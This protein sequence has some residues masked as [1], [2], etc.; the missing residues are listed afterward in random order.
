MKKLLMLTAAVLALQA[1]PA[2]AQDGGPDGG[3]KHH[4]GEKFFEMQDTNKDGVISEDEALANAKKRFG[5][6]DG[7]KDGKI[8]KE[9]A[10]THHEAMK[11]KWKEKRAE[12]KKDAAPPAEEAP[13]E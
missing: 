2:L 9:E 10:Q 11:A 3:K 13:A 1:L 8:T 7:N 4:R 6:M 5:E 12:M